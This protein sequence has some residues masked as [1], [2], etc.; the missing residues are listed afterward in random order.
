MARKKSVSN[1]SA[2]REEIV[3]YDVKRLRQM[4]AK[5][6]QDYYDRVEPISDDEV[7]AIYDRVMPKIA[8]EIASNNQQKKPRHIVSSIKKTVLVAVCMT[9]M[10]SVV[11]QALGI[12]VWEVILSWTHEH[13]L[14]HIQ[15]THSSEFPSNFDRNTFSENEIQ[16]WG[17]DFCNALHE[18]DFYPHLPTQK[19]ADLELNDL[20]YTKDDWGSIYVS[21]YFTRTDGH[22]LSLVI[23]KPTDEQYFVSYDVFVERSPEQAQQRSINGVDFYFFTNIDTNTFVW[24]D[25]NIIYTVIT[26]LSP[27]IIWD[28]LES[29]P[30]E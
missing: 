27:D 25:T 26:S 19:P 12:S 9:L 24:Y 11:A 6:L 2:R 13:L 8:Y 15:S 3:D 21:A 4:S 10:L 5:E 7:N 17:D 30:L 23:E 1:Q 20:F 14:I 16:T 28:M 22:T 18:L 29:F